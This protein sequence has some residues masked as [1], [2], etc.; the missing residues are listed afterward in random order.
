MPQPTNTGG[1][2]GY[3]SSVDTGQVQPFVLETEDISVLTYTAVVAGSAYFS[4]YVLNA[5][6]TVTQMRCSFTGSPTGSVSMGIY[7]ATG[8]NNAPGNLICQTGANAAATGN[9][10]KS[11][12]ANQIL[13]PGQYWLAFLDTVADS[14]GLRAGLSSGMGAFLK[15]T[16]TS[17]TVLPATAGAVADIANRI[18]V[19]ALLLNSF[20]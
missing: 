5:Q 18:G 19:M 1:L 16:S 11:L 3:P 10:T 15:T 2:M 4:P 6:V 14:V 13:P 8:A 17:L 20:S 12:T 9:F 7:D